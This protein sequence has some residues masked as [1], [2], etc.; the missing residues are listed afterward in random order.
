MKR[1][2]FYT[3]VPLGTPGTPITPDVPIPLKAPAPLIMPGALVSLET[4]A[5]PIDPGALVPLETPVPPERRI[6]SDGPSKNTRSKAISRGKE[7]SRDGSP[8]LQVCPLREV[9]MEGMQGGVG[10]VN[11]RLNSSEVRAFKKELKGLLDDPIALSE[12]VDHFLGPTTYSW[13]EMHSILGMLFTQEEKQVIRM[14]GM[15]IWEKEHRNGQQNGE[16]KMPIPPGITTPKR[17]G[18]TWRTIG[19]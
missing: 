5:P 16:E 9:P 4:P 14:T 18:E 6:P 13:D 1:E 11:V 12:Q 7:N 19:L 10:F 2:K 3:P 15:R 17:E 8:R